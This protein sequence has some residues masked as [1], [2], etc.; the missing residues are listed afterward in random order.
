MLWVWLSAVLTIG[1]YFVTHHMNKVPVL[2][3]QSPAP[4]ESVFIARYDFST[5][6]SIHKYVWPK[7]SFSNLSYAPSNLVVLQG[8]DSLFLKNSWMKLRSDAAMALYAMVQVMYREIGLPLTVVSWYRTFAHQTQLNPGHED[9]FRAKPGHS[10]HQS[11]LA[12]D[13]LGLTEWSIAN[14]PRKNAVYV[15]MLANAHRFWFTQSYQKWPWIDGYEREP[16]HRRFVGMDLASIL[17]DEWLTF[18]EF[19]IL[20]SRKP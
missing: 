18:T 15:W 1:G 8:S 11:W 2:V 13:V 9:V 20:Q 16:W 17:Q 12:V 7:V 3:N 4:Q 6:S 5:D 19:Y 10:E 14:D